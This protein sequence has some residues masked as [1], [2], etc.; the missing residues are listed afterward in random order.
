[1]HNS[2]NWSYFRIC[3][4]LQMTHNFILKLE[5]IDTGKKLLLVPSNILTLTVIIDFCFVCGFH[6]SQQIWSCGDGQFT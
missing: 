4:S 3:S 6:P 1:M 5:L 2:R